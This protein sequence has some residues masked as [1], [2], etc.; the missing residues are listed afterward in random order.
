M[1]STGWTKLSAADLPPSVLLV[2]S[3]AHRRLFRRVTGVVHHGGA[4][5]DGG[6]RAGRRAASHRA[7]SFTR[8]GSAAGRYRPV[9]STPH[10]WPIGCR[11][12]LVT[13]RRR[14]ASSA[15]CRSMAAAVASMR[16]CST[17]LP[18]V[19]TAK[20]VKHVARPVELIYKE[21]RMRLRRPKV[22]QIP[23]V[24]EFLQS[25]R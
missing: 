21:A 16:S 17:P 5:P 2:Q 11:I 15:V 14:R 24:P 10:V 20:K 22:A 18:N 25:N 23:G 7:A 19:L 9:S 3:V 4:G 13:L 8:S 12:S 6:R 1:L